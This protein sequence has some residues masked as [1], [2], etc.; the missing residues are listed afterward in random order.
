MNTGPVKMAGHALTETEIRP[1]VF[2]RKPLATV[3]R[4]IPEVTAVKVSKI[5]LMRFIN[6]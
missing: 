6:L 2:T 5:V 3:Y 1:R 4:P